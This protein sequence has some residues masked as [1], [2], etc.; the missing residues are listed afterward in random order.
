MAESTPHQI[1]TYPVQ[2]DSSRNIPQQQQQHQQNQQQKQ[3][4][5]QQQLPPEVLKTC[6]K[7]RNEI[8]T[9]KERFVHDQRA[10][11]KECLTCTVCKKELYRMKKI[12]TGQQKSNTGE[13]QYYC[14][15]CYADLYAPRCG[16]CNKP[17]TQYMLS[18]K[19]AD[20]IYHRECFVCGRCKKSL[21]NKEFSKFG[22]LNVCKSCV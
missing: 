20:K 9:E 12:E 2:A 22:N 18:T 21:E 19:N 8:G 16:K 10:Y 13:T 3:Q 14:E 4:Q 17:V 7:C 6:A 15:P 1:E 5:Q 11:H